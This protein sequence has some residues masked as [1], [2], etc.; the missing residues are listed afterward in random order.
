MAQVFETRAG[1]DGDTDGGGAAVGSAQ[2]AGGA[3]VCGQEV[4]FV[5][6][7]QAGDVARADFFEYAVDVVGLA[8]VIGAGGVDDVQDEVGERGFFESGGEGGD[9]AVRQ[10][11]HEA[12]GVG[13]DD[14]GSGSEV[15]AA[16]GGVEGGEKLVFG[17]DVGFGQAVEQAGFSGI[18]VAGE[19]EGGQA[20]ALAGFAAG[21]ALPFDGFEPFF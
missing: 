18:G 15:E 8:F 2:E 12:D 1:F 11:A 10:V 4:G 19:G 14:F 21:G 5:V 6:H 16:G 13:E 3:A 7:E 17:E 20:A 9:E